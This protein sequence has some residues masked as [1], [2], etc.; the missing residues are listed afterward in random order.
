MAEWKNEENV[1][2]AATCD[3]IL[4]FI[5]NKQWK[6]FEWKLWDQDKLREPKFMICK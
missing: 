3:Y 5:K 4:T 1:E 2:K 6:L